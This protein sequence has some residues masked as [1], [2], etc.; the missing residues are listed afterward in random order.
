MKKYVIILLLLSIALVG[1]NTDSGQKMSFKQ[2]S[3]IFSHTV[4]NI[5]KQATVL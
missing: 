3:S 4:Q 1:C 5:Q 2:A